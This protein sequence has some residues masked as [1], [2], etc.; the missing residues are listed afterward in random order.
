MK[1]EE[2][3]KVIATYCDYCGAELT[4]VNHSSITLLNGTVMDFCSTYT[5]KISETCFDKFK[6]DTNRK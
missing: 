1:K 3:R 2:L 4:G 6:K 5:G